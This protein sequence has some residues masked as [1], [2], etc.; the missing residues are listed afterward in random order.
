MMLYMFYICFY[1][2]YWIIASE[3]KLYLASYSVCI[4]L[5][6]VKFTSRCFAIQ[7]CL[8]HSYFNLLH[9]EKPVYCCKGS[10]ASFRECAQEIS[11]QT[12]PRE[13]RVGW[14]RD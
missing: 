8:Q 6:I 4:I 7:H 3:N 12:A 11:H 13:A 9:F 14:A 2:T 5:C 10:D 1:H